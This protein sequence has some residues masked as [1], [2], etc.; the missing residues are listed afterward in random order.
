MPR[1]RKSD[2]TAAEDEPPSP[3]S[4]D[5]ATPTTGWSTDPTHCPYLNQRIRRPIPPPFFS[6][7]KIVGTIPVTVEDMPHRPT[8]D[9]SLGEGTVV[10]YKLAGGDGGIVTEPGQ[11]YD[12]DNV[13]TSKED[14]TEEGEQ[15]TDGK[16]RFRN[17]A[18]TPALYKIIYD[19]PDGDAAD[20]DDSS[21]APTPPPYTEDLTLTELE[22]ALSAATKRLTSSVPQ[23]QLQICAREVV[24]Y[25]NA[26]AVRGDE[27]LEMMISGLDGE[28]M[29][30]DKLEGTLPL[31][32]R[33][34][35]DWL[36]WYCL[37][38]FYQV[39]CVLICCCVHFVHIYLLRCYPRWPV[40]YPKSVHVCP[41]VS[42]LPFL[43][44]HV[45]L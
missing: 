41:N 4:S 19:L 1:K 26:L 15:Q 38:L 7:V 2:P 23:S 13:T 44:I 17:A 5:P 27:A 37:V 40:R 35:T 31:P 45:R 39:A 20:D 9:V 42:L 10:A 34:V 14:E 25:Y 21:T 16:P 28:G 18:R 24:T 11:D 29:D 36:F 12:P 43:Q 6:S 30:V 3:S 22:P 8:V 32:L 33:C